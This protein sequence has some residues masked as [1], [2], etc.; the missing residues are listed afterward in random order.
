MK[1]NSYRDLNVWKKSMAELETQLL[2]AARRKYV[3]DR[4]SVI[5]KAVHGYK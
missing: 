1:I 4:V 3:H 5:G 2:I